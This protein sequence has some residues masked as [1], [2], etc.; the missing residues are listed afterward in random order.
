MSD[1]QKYLDEKLKDVRIDNA[2]SSAEVP[3]YD[4]YSGI[5]ES[6][7]SERKRRGM[8]QKELSL[9]TGMSQAAISNIEN[10]T[11]KPTIDSLRRMADAL[12]TRLNITF[13]DGEE[14]I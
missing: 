6:L 14:E 12:G 2:E 8:S 13:V 11:T 1:F 3:D 9:K 4:V 10:G 5:R 7:V